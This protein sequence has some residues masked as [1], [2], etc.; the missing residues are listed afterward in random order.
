MATGIFGAFCQ[1]CG[2]SLEG[3]VGNR[4]PECGRRFDSSDSRT[5]DAE[6]GAHLRRRRRRLL[7]AVLL[8]P[9][10][11]IPVIWLSVPIPLL[12]SIAAIVGIISAGYLLWKKRWFAGAAVALGSPLT[13]NFGLGAIDYA[14]ASGAVRFH[15]LPST[16]C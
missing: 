13:V 3:L 2:Y 15:G 9:L 14:N 7:R 16:L 8:G 11:I 1:T 12:G 5:Y 10:T 4:C 6:P